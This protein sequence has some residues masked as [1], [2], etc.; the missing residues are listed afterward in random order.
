M[1]IDERFLAP[2]EARADEQGQKCL[3]VA[4]AYHRSRRRSSRKGLRRLLMRYRNERGTA[5]ESRSRETPGDA[6]T[7]ERDPVATVNQTGTIRVAVVAVGWVAV[8]LA[9]GGLPCLLLEGRVA[10][11][12]VVR[13]MGLDIDRRL[14]LGL[15]SQVRLADYDNG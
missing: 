7:T 4:I 11:L 8:V 5:G 15:G 9:L 6:Q 1:D 13:V 3:Y 14:G 10:S 12:V 2:M